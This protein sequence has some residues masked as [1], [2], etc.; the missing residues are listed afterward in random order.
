MCIEVSTEC[1]TDV[2]TVGCIAP[3][4]VYRSLIARNVNV[5]TASEYGRTTECGM[6]EE[7]SV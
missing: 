4:T 5:T 7:S 1:G 6:Y 3:A 2:S